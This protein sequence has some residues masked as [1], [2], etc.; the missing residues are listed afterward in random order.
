MLELVSR[1]KPEAVE[2]SKSARDMPH[3]R[4]NAG[5]G[6][7]WIRMAFVQKRL[8]DYFQALIDRKDLL[9]EFYEDDAFV[10][11]EEAVAIGGLLIGLN[12]IECNEWVC[13]G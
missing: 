6:R 5:R 9:T 13:A 1:L 8:S 7:T 12:V 10:M 11:S 2:L 4:T 3:V